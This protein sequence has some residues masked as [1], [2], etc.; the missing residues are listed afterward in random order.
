[1][2]LESPS[3]DTAAE[4]SARLLH[5]I[6]HTLPRLDRRGR[7]WEPVV[8]DTPLFASGLLDSLS[9]LHLIAAIEE[10]TGQPVPD[11]L[12]VMK[13]FASVDAVSAAFSP[14]PLPAEEPI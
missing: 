12:V 2:L 13:H 9:I 5:F 1:M 11:R 4:F 6:N 3:V 7:H 8:A 14:T 10:F